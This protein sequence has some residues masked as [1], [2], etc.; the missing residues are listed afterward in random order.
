[1]LTQILVVK[2]DW[3][4]ENVV[5]FTVLDPPRS[6]NSMIMLVQEVVNSLDYMC[7]FIIIICVHLRLHL[8]IWKHKMFSFIQ[9]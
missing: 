7:L 8:D 6:L 9:M 5:K 2:C 3:S 1:M 4:A